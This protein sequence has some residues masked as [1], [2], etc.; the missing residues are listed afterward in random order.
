MKNFFLIKFG[1][2]SSI[3]WLCYYVEDMRKKE[4]I[5]KWVFKDIFNFLYFYEIYVGNGV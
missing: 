1:K 4:N 2:K 5:N 3:I